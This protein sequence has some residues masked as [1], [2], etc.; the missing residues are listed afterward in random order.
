MLYHYTTIFYD[1]RP[2]VLDGCPLPHLYIKQTIG[3]F[4]VGACVVLALEQ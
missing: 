2:T 3:I 4:L 1:D